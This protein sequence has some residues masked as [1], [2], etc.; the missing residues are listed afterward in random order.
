MGLEAVQTVK[1]IVLPL[2]IRAV[3][4]GALLGA[5]VSAGISGFST[6]QAALY[7][8]QFG[9]WGLNGGQIFFMAILGLLVGVLAALA[10]CAGTIAAL[11]VEAAQS[12]SVAVPRELTAGLGAGAV[13]VIYSVIVFSVLG[14]TGLAL[15]GI[16]FGIATVSGALAAFHT[17]LLVRRYQSAG[18]TQLP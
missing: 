1:I 4:T 3:F 10:T 18:Q 7:P 2:V 11:W 5:F 13:T 9:L 17:R 14:T 8:E 16:G 12:S 15:V 6:L